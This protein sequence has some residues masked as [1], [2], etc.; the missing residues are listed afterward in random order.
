[1]VST[2]GDE[3]RTYEDG[4]SFNARSCRSARGPIQLFTAVF[5]VR[6]IS[7]SSR[8]G[9][10]YQLMTAATFRSAGPGHWLSS[11]ALSGVIAASSARCPPAE[12]PDTTTRDASMLYSLACSYTHRSAQWQSSAAAGAGACCSSR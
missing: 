2:G 3:A 8:F 10:P 11:P 1:M 6:P 7:T 5:A 12:F 4:D 9:N